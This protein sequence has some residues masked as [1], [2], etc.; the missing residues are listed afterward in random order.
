DSLSLRSP[1]INAAVDREGLQALLDSD[2]LEL[3]TP[4]AWA[5][6]TNA[7]S[8]N[9]SSAN[10]A[11]VGGAPYNLDGTAQVVGVWDGGTD[12]DTHQDFQNAPSPSLITNATRRARRIN[13]NTAA[14]YPTHVTGTI[15][16]DGTGN[17]NARG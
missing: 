9:M 6:I 13:T 17:A 12:R 14:Q 3:I 15:V 7:V 2:L 11:A 4:I 8:T 1:W 10:A 16:A 5:E